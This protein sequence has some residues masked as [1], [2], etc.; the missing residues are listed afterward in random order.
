MRCCGGRYGRDPPPPDLSG[1]FA[2]LHYALYTVAQGAELT[3]SVV[4]SLVVYSS[5][6][7]RQVF[8]EN[9]VQV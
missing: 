4:P 1:V 7:P 2:P 5:T 9:S 8:N 3:V 6:K